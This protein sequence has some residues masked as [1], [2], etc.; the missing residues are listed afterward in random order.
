MLVVGSVL[1]V[2]INKA[3]HDQEN[4]DETSKNNEPC[5]ENKVKQDHEKSINSKNHNRYS[6]P[7]LDNM[8]DLLN[9]VDQQLKVCRKFNVKMERNLN[10]PV[11]RYVLICC[12]YIYSQL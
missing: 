10:D 12:L 3:K 2:P 8:T 9:K 4:L 6:D 11:R 5:H 7:H 1:R